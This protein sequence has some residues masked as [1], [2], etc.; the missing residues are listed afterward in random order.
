MNKFN[1]SNDSQTCEQQRWRCASVF[2]LIS[3]SC[4]QREETAYSLRC[5]LLLVVLWLGSAVDSDV[6]EGLDKSHLGWNCWGSKTWEWQHDSVWCMWKPD[7]P[8]LLFWYC[9][10]TITWALC[11]VIHSL[12]DQHEQLKHPALVWSAVYRHK[13][14]LCGRTSNLFSSGM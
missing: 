2:C 8:H 9:K 7:N 5:L 11:V 6:S 3:H 1:V 14:C 10:G 4:H 12:Q 13:K